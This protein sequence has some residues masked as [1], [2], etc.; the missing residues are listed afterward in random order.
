[1]L[2]HDSVMLK[3]TY[4]QS[5]MNDEQ[6]MHLS[7]NGGNFLAREFEWQRGGEV[8]G[9]HQRGCNEGNQWILQLECGGGA[10]DRHELW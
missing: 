8:V 9:W 5:M 4:A 10:C 6:Q 3:H 1:M 2:L 7:K